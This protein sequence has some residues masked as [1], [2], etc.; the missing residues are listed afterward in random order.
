MMT[1]GRVKPRK[2]GEFSE[3]YYVGWAELAAPSEL[4]ARKPLRELLLLKKGLL[5]EP[6][7]SGLVSELSPSS[8]DIT[9]QLLTPSP[10]STHQPP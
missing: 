3:D 4:G 5:R 8:C 10:S 9:H 2:D 6:N 1:Q 7:Q